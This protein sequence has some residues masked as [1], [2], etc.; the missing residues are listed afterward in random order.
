VHY[1]RQAWGGTHLSLGSII[2]SY[3]RCFWHSGNPTSLSVPMCYAFVTPIPQQ[4][5]AHGR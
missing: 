1:P 2:L 3:S 5:A 4:R